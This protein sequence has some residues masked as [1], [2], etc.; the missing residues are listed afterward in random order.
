MPGCAAASPSACP[1]TRIGVNQDGV[2]SATMGRYNAE[3]DDGDG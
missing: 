3:E 1:R 2:H